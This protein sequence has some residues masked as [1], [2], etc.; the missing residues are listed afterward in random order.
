MTDYRGVT[1]RVNYGEIA[2]REQFRVGYIGM[3][4]F[5]AYFPVA[6]L[7]DLISTLNAVLSLNLGVIARGASVQ[8][9]KVSDGL[10]TSVVVEPRLDT[11]TPAE[12]MRVR[13]SD[14]ADIL[15][16]LTLFQADVTKKPDDWD[17]SKQIPLSALH[18]SQITEQI[19]ED[20]TFGEQFATA[21]QGEKA[22]G[23]AQKSQNLSDLTDKAAARAALDV[24]S[25]GQ[26]ATTEQG[27]K[28][29]DAVSGNYF[30]I[31]VN[32]VD[33]A[34]DTSG[35]NDSAPGIQA[36]IELAYATVIANQKAAN[37][38]A[39]NIPIK[40]DV[41]IPA[42]L[43]K[44]NSPVILKPGVNVQLSHAAV[45]KAG[46]AMTALFD[47]QPTVLLQ[48]QGI[49]GGVFDCN[50]LAQSAIYLR[51]AIATSIKDIRVN[52]PAT[53]GII[54]GDPASTA[55]SY[56]IN[57]AKIDLYR[58]RNTT[59]PAGSRGI[60]MQNV[61]DSFI[62]EIV[63][64]GFEIGFRNDGGN[65][66]FFSCHPWNPT[67]ANGPSICFDENG[68]NSRYIDCYADS[69][70]G[71]GWR[72][73]KSSI[74]HLERCTW[75]LSLSS[76]TDYSTAIYCDGTPTLH[77]SGSIYGTWE[78]SDTGPN[79]RRWLNDIVYAA[80]A[81]LA[82][83]T[84]WDAVV[85]QATVI[86]RAYSTRSHRPGLSL[87][88]GSLAG[89]LQFNRAAA[90]II[91]SYKDVAGQPM[92][93]SVNAD[94]GVSHGNGAALGGAFYSGSG[95]PANT[96]GANGDFYHRTDTPTVANQRL[97]AKSAGA[98]VGIL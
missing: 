26:A 51:Y 50:S 95:V 3:E 14:I 28:A 69:P 4:S 44:I 89:A 82:T 66:R 40:R 20:P 5:E 90:D 58:P 21:A 63:P 8:A 72:L 7:S 98:W 70:Y 38:D 39:V 15:Y 2:E 33:F 47:S 29:D 23:S 96:L 36:A 56:E 91:R 64:R 1:W 60:W 87:F 22:D 80:G 94:G 18:V 52:D 53:H 57:L 37:N 71:Y 75:Y 77:V 30:S 34:V 10:L 62:S 92:V 17:I 41:Y 54:I 93:Y 86:N 84:R 25:K 32:P 12:T 43:Y 97:Y 16:A 9:R 61:S 83:R 24:Y 35:I 81:Q 45:I 73:R 85:D 11:G 49:T 76:T 27:K 59:A 55:V 31:V 68:S 78:D 65:N 19:N 6:Q 46:A 48:R 67:G 42:G 79:T 13:L 74:V 88:V